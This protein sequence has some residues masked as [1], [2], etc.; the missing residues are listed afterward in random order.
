MAERK[1]WLVIFCNGINRFYVSVPVQFPKRTVWSS[2]IH[3]ETAA[4]QP[5]E[6][7]RSHL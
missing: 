2:N 7:T 4:T 1:A 3:R 5:R 6:D